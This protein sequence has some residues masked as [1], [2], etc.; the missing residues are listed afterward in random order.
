MIYEFIAFVAL[1]ESFASSFRMGGC[2]HF[3]S[4]PSF[5]KMEVDVD[6]LASKW[7]LV[8]YGQ[9]ATL[10]YGVEQKP[11]N[12]HYQKPETI[13]VN[14]EGGIGLDLVEAMDMGDNIGGM[15][16]VGGVRPGSNAEK[17]GKFQIGDVLVGL[18]S[19]SIEGLNYD[20]T[21]DE[22]VKRVEN[23]P[24]D[25]KIT[26]QRLVSAT[27]LEDITGKVFFD[28]DIG[29]ESA[30]R[31]TIGL[32]GNA[33][34][35]T[36]ENFR[37]LATG[38]MGMGKKGKPLAYK[39]SPFHRIIPQFMLQGGDF[40]DKD[41]FGGESIYGETF[42]DENFLISHT[43]EGLLSMANAG[44]NTQASQFFI[45]TA[46]T[47]WLNG[48]HVVFGKVIDGMNVVKAI[49]KLGSPSG[50]PLKIV[51]ISDCGEVK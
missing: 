8:K 37:A 23:G 1:F 13:S 35:R 30:G 22:L 39:G 19:N 11:S 50:K 28:I 41:G 12:T 38:E 42:P 5:L 15:V 25:L 24:N 34:P 48:K 7:K 49:E 47:P 2:P 46:V 40:T 26:V 14:T 16:M 6:L 20:L 27:N 4:K 18:D 32:Y 3:V 17:A 33:T 36:C 45:T 43:S 51:T 10:R 21:M 29:G 31:I 9:G 44:P